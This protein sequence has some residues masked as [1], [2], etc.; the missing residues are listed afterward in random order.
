MNLKTRIQAFATLG[1]ELKALTPEQIQE[2]AFRAGS[3]NPWFDKRNVTSALN[4][5]ISQLDY[6]Y[7]QEW[8]FVYDLEEIYP[9]RIGV[10][11]SGTIPMAGF[12]DFL[13]VLV[14]GHYL[15]ARLSTEDTFLMNMLAQ[16][17]IR[18]E[19]QF[20]FRIYFVNILKDVEAVIATSNNEM[21]RNLQKYFSKKPYIIRE[22]QNSLGILTGK[23]TPDELAKLGTDIFQYYGL[24]TRSVSKLLVPAG[25]VFNTFFEAI[26]SFSYMLDHHRYQNNYDYNKSLLLVNRVYHF[27]N[28]FLLVTP[29]QEYISPISVLFYQ[30]YKNPEELKELVISSQRKTQC[31]VSADGWYG[32]S[33]A[34]GQ[35][36]NPALWD[37]ANGVDTIGF[38]ASL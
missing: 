2:L 1:N 30:E 35:T 25:Y 31:L 14:S 12:S 15:Y 21:A 18:I 24:S 11:M 7:L 38:L 26:E 5:I 36:Q 3:N 13:S 23:E 6:K 8:L 19:P 34:F 22:V 32:H 10:V 33:I 20:A 27:D 4:G 9:K 28:N 37:Y 17:L 16:C 29:S